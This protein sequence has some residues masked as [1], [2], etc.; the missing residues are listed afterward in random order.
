MCGCAFCCC[1]LDPSDVLLQRVT[2]NTRRTEQ[3]YEFF[4]DRKLHIKY[5]CDFERHRR[6]ARP[7]STVY[8]TGVGRPSIGGHQLPP[9]PPQTFNTF[10]ARLR[11]LLPGVIMKRTQCKTL[12]DKSQL[13]AETASYTGANNRTSP[14]KLN[15]VLLAHKSLR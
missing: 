1:D 15:Y 14:I 10:S 5:W 9:P 7:T 11:Y 12:L 13:M 6:P 4:T 2:Y 8:C 3:L